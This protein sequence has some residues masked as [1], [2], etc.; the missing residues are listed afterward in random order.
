MKKKEVFFSSVFITISY[1]L[2]A[3]LVLFLFIID[4]S[5]KRWVIDTISIFQVINVNPYFDMVRLHNSGAAFSFLS[6]ASGWQRWFFIVVGIAAISW[7]VSLLIDAI[8]SSSFLLAASLALIIAGALGNT[9]DR[10]FFG[11]VVDFLS[12]HYNE[13]RYPAF[14]AADTFISCGACLYIC[15]VIKEHRAH[16]K[17]Y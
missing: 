6:D 7:F 5:S 16:S 9:W 17:R 12:F 1:A 14:N 13:W 3:A 11:Y 8:R 15:N 10:L 4:F 2:W